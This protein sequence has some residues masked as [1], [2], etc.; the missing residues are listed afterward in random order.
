MTCS[1]T[2]RSIFMLVHIYWS[3]KTTGEYNEKDI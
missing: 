3:I 1:E 2:S